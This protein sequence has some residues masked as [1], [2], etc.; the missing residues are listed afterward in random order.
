MAQRVYTVQ[1][2]N[3]AV[4]AVQDLISLQPGASCGIEIHEIVLGQITATS[5]GNLRLTMKRFSSTFSAGSGGSTPTPG[6]HNFNDAAALTAAHANDTTQISA[7]T[8][9]TIRGDI[10]NV[11]NGYQYL[12][13]PE[14]RIQI[15]PSQAFVLSLDTAPGSSETMSGSLTFAELM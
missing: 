13:A 10:Y 4:S 6:K 7:G 11:V 12:P 9:V 8:S 1:F 2:N 3:V 5:V 15:P 14:D